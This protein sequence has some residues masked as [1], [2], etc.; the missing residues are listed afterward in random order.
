M[1]S[2]I[3]SCK[4]E[5]VVQYEEADEL[6][7]YDMDTRKVVFR[8]EKPQ[9]P[10][11]IEELVE[12]YDVCAIITAGITPENR[13]FFEGIG[14]KPVLVDKNLVDKVINDIFA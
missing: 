13:M 2:V 14:V 12:D 7:I 11:L 10:D 1:T 9:D 8:G 3:I 4:K 5:L 6:L